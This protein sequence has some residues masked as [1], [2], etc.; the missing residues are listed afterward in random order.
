MKFDVSHKTLYRYGQAV[1]QSQHITHLAP[2]SLPLQFVHT[3]NLTVEPVPASRLDG[4]DAFGNA[5]AILDIEEPHRELILHS[6][7]TVEVRAPQWIDMRAG[8]SWDALDGTLGTYGSASADLDTIQYR[9]AT[10]LTPLSADIAEYATVSF[11][12]GRAVLDGSM[13]L[14]RRIFTEFTFDASATDISTPIALVFRKRRGVCQDFAHLAL[15]CLYSRR[16]YTTVDTWGRYN[17]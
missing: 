6:R 13:D 5:I 3:H 7:S 17:R 16:G 15:A 12:P 9:C 14:T 2:R 1:A 4:L 10:R 8:L 11:A